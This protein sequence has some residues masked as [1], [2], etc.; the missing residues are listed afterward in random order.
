MDGE[1]QGL[2]GHGTGEFR[3][4][5]SAMALSKHYVDLFSNHIRCVHRR[6]TGSFFGMAKDNSQN[7][8]ESRGIPSFNWIHMTT[9]I[10]CMG[11]HIHTW[12]DALMNAWTYIH[13]YKQTNKQTNDS[14]LTTSPLCNFWDRTKLAMRREIR[15]RLRRRSRRGSTDMSR[16]KSRWFLTVLA[17]RDLFGVGRSWFLGEN[18]TQTRSAGQELEGACRPLEQNIR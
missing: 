4:S 11:T 9:H 7:C 14:H 1:I 3:P 5:T 12:M 15:S 16:R 13:I 8:L 6:R 2:A 10:L 17:A 18:K